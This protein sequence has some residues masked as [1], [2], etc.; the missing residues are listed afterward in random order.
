MLQE[1][2]E[3]AERVVSDNDVARVVRRYSD[4]EL[5]ASSILILGIFSVC[6]AASAGVLWLDAG[7]MMIAVIMAV[8]FAVSGV[9]VK[10]SYDRRADAVRGMAAD[11]SGPMMSA[12]IEEM[13]RMNPDD[14]AVTVSRTEM[15]EAVR[16]GFE[17]RAES[18]AIVSARPMASTRN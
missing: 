1:P 17:K 11:L 15:I 3:F 9:I 14:F 8:S 16:E 12:R 6:F 4:A 2:K 10:V 5:Q 13:F 18:V 7:A